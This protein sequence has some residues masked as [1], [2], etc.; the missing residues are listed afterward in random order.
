MKCSNCQAEIKDDSSFC[1]KCGTDIE[2]KPKHFQ[3]NKC[4]TINDLGSEFCRNCKSKDLSP[5]PS[6][7]DSL[8]LID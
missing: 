2:Y 3:C 4:G 1:L 5:E 6:P 8:F 7:K